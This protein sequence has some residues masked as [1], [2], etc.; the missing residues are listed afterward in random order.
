MDISPND[1]EGRRVVPVL[2]CVL[3]QLTLRNDKHGFDPGKVTIFHALKPPAISI[4]S[5]LER[6]FKYASCSPEC[7]VLALVY[8]D[9]IIQR[10]QMLI[11]SLNV[12]RLIITSIMVAAKFFDDNY[13]NNAYYARV[14]GVPTTELNSLELEFLFL[15]NFSLHVPSDIFQKYREELHMHTFSPARPCFCEPTNQME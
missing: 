12:H 14:G 1:E 8:V 3:N 11:T 10:N 13:Y 6:I 5:Y 15:I 7:F 2:S 4:R 9:R